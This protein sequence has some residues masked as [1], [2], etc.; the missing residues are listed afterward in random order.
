MHPPKIRSF[1]IPNAVLLLLYLALLSCLAYHCYRHGYSVGGDVGAMILMLLGILC[2]GPFC[3]SLITIKAKRNGDFTL[4]KAYSNSA[5]L[6]V[7]VLVIFLLLFAF[8]Y[9]VVK[10]ND[11]GIVACKRAPAISEPLPAA[12]E[13]QAAPIPC[14]CKPT[15]ASA[16]N[17]AQA[18][19]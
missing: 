7:L 11:Y 2:V 14:E 19:E 18:N 12:N 4:A 13:A 6:G 1:L 8:A 3:L 16:S 10:D 5:F 15:P 9:A 17:E